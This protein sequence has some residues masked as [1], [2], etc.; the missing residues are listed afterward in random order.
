MAG[1]RGGARR[2]AG[3]GARALVQTIDFRALFADL[4]SPHM[5][6]DRR[7]VYVE[8]NAAYLQTVGRSREALIGRNIFEVF[9]NTDE[10]GRM[11]RASF[12]RV[13]ATGE[14]DSIAHIP[15]AIADET[16]EPAMRY[17]SA[18]HLPLFDT[19]GSV[20]FI[21]QNTV[22]VTE[23]R[24]L[25]LLALE[26]GRSSS[27][28]LIGETQLLQRAVEVQRKNTSLVKET[29]R[30]QHLFLQ[31]PGFMALLD[32]PDLKFSFVN[33]AMVRLVGARPLIGRTV[34]Q[35]MPEVVDQGFVDL[36]RQSVLTGEPFVGRGMRVELQRGSGGEL[37]ERFA[38]FIFQ[39]IFAEGGEALGVFVEGSDVTERVW[40]ERQQKLLVDELNHRVKNTLATVQAIAAQTLRTSPDPET[41]RANFEARLFALSA[42]HDLLTAASWRS[43]ALL[44]VLRAELR[45]HGAER[46]ELEGPDVALAPPQALTLGL[47][48]HELATN[49][50]KYGALS[51]P[52][53]Q[54]RVGWRVDEAAGIAD[55]VLDW[56]EAGGPP[57]SPPARRG[58]GSRLIERSLKGEVG[59][60]ATLDFAPD[61]LRCRL[62]L[63]L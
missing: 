49:A 20:K 6:L 12:E 25:K 57:V 43:A 26:S 63:P 35:A 28:A 7:L 47:I 50:A 59:G 36:L 30:L 31:A 37:E 2:L 56:I 4:P 9:P 15:Y 1:R 41:F 32:Y 62:R 21:V 3:G 53:G 51:T 54:L 39:P 48:V 34:A 18:V 52:H 24:E 45:P 61:G 27:A 44:D 33:Q 46:Y 5:I 40:A 8:A 19:D 29:S 58:F 38:D 14:S 23:L 17:W 10:G 11:L 60:E 22:D 13:L 16:G 42:T 55:L